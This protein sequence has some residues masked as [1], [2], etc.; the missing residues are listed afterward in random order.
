MSEA[1][2]G[3]EESESSFFLALSMRDVVTVF[4]QSTVVPKTSKASALGGDVMM[5]GKFDIFATIL[6]Y[7]PRYIRQRLVLKVTDVRIQLIS[8]KPYSARFDLTSKLSD[9]CF[10]FRCTEYWFLGLRGDGPC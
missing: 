3:D 1:E 8:I 5:S 10:F 7:Y 4:L 6:V 2:L 9:L